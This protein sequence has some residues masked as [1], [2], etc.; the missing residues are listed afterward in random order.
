LRSDD[1]GGPRTLW[2]CLRFPALPVDVF[3]RAWSAGDHARPF[4]VGSG[5]HYPR[6]IGGN[7]AAQ[8]AG[9]Q[10]DQL[11][12][13]ALALAPGMAIRDR[14]VAAEAQALCD[15]AERVLVFTPHTCIASPDAVLA[16]IGG[17]ERL[18][19]GLR[20]LLQRLLHDVRALGHAPVPALAPTP[21]AAL[22]L[23]RAGH[24]RPVLACDALAHA[25]DGLPVRLLDVDSAAGQLLS[26]AGI[27]TIGQLAALPRAG[28]A[29][30][31][32]PAL[33]D[34]LDR[35]LGRIPD[36]RAP[37]QSPPRFEA[38]L[39]LPAPVEDTAALGFGLHRLVQQLSHWLTARGLGVTRLALTLV[40]ER[41]LRE[42]GLPSTEVPF[43]LGAP[44]RALPH[45]QGVLRE[46][47]ARITLPA[48]VEALVLASEETAPL[49]GRNLGLLP[50][51]ESQA[52]DVPLL[53]RL[54][55][56]LGDDAVMRVAPHP[57]HRPEQAQR[58][59][60]PASLASGKSRRSAA[61]PIGAHPGAPVDAPPR[62]LWLLDAPQPLGETLESRPWIL[63][64]GPE[65][66]ESGWWDGRD[67]RR[68]YFVAATPEGALMWI[69]RDHRH[70]TDDGEWFLHGVYA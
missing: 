15:V 13:A 29:R 63:R 33:V 55:A 51:D 50:G 24:A 21:A 68:D 23:A 49:A 17:S 26:A 60:V 10:R 58:E 48:P 5:G 69:Y 44:A 22:L 53:E 2:V 30:R 32:G 9:V 36:A 4:V 25:L 45:L 39:P 8:A 11:V 27:T 64:D 65:R 62:P 52:V 34:A 38:R 1:R 46:R 57:E 66:I 19:G 6:V 14:D 70:G 31:C 35:A 43:A 61:P 20:P 67:L 16:E 41:Y 28:L 59:A 12:S 54:R 40:H 18:F 7:A 42:R 3:A 56:R 37:Y 47:L